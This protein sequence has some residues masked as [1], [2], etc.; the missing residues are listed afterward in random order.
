MRPARS[1]SASAKLSDLATR[2]PWWGGLL[3]ALATYVLLHPIAILQM[4]APS[5]VV[6]MAATVL[7]RI[8]IFLAQIGQYLLPLVFLASATISGFD[9]WKRG[10]L[11][12]SVARDTSGSMLRG[13]RWPDFELLVGEAFRRQGY[14][15]APPGTGLSESGNGLEMTKNNRLYLVDCTDWRSWR[16]GA[17][18]VRHLHECVTTTGA[19]GG[20]A[21]TSGQ[22][23]PEAKHFAADKNI[24]LI[25]GRHFKELIRLEARATQ[26]DPSFSPGNPVS[27]LAA[28]AGRI[29]RGLRRQEP[30][31]DILERPNR[32][33]ASPS[34]DA[35]LGP[36]PITPDALPHV[37][38]DAETTA[39]AQ[40]S[41]LIRDERNMDAGIELS[42]PPV[43]VDER[44]AP[45][46]RL[47][48]PRIRFRKIADII[49]ML[50]ATGL[51]WN[52]YEWFGQLPEA[53]SDWPWSLLGGGSDSGL[54]ARRLEGIELSESGSRLQEGDRPLGQFQFGPPG[55]IADLKPLVPGPG[56]YGS[57]RELEAAFEAKYV[58]PPECYTWES[59]KQ[60][61]RCGNHRI[62]ARREFIASGGEETPMLFGSWEEPSENWRPYEEWIQQQGGE[63]QWQPYP[64]AER[65][66][67]QADGREF[68]QP[69]APEYA[70]EPDQDRRREDDPRSGRQSDPE[71]DPQR[72]W[73]QE[74]AADWRQDFSRDWGQESV[75]PPPLA[76]QENWGQEWVRGPEQIPNMGWRAEWRQQPGQSPEAG[77]GQD[78][79]RDWVPGTQT[80]DEGDLRPSWEPAPVEN[81]HWVDDL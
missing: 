81:R 23:T 32:A 5:G 63:T 57:L 40:L 1:R 76:P 13:L 48:R 27:T 51:L 54:L 14:K 24:E 17:G 21:V 22:F 39:G 46:K 62:R 53:P 37:A 50:F 20:F 79:R 10:D 12:E 66:R 34:A 29:A 55:R 26:D 42:A 58:P 7:A 71:P 61:V 6:D 74:S 31:T 16:A 72:S 64:S 41:A 60:M 15:I 2:L 75:D 59:N 8:F 33:D 49:G 3:C 69:G 25:D 11:R 47:P 78:W 67:Q 73:R 30:Q 52:T 4:P 45:R 9:R 19:Q 38:E 35:C 56:S 80:E 68:V 70:L 18:A 36:V 77:S 43:Q 28:S 44:R 65:E